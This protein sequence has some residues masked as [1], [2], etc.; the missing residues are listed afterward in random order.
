MDVWLLP[1][2]QYNT[3][4]SITRKIFSRRLWSVPSNL[5]SGKC[6]W[7]QVNRMLLRRVLFVSL[8]IRRPS[9]PWCTEPG[10]RIR[11]F[12]ASAGICSCPDSALTA[13]RYWD[14]W[15]LWEVGTHCF[16]SNS[17]GSE[18]LP[19][20][21]ICPVYVTEAADAGVGGD[22][23]F[24]IFTTGSASREMLRSWPPIPRPWSDTIENWWNLGVDYLP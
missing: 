8:A 13:L 2:I 1:Q 24:L 19:A 3:I 16:I 5:T 15:F 17:G 11:A 14:R 18:M 4:T 21:Q 22:S 9:L 12:P 10:S 20:S 7:G 23:S 6:G